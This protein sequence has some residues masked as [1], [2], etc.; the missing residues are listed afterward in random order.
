MLRRAVLRRA[1]LRRALLR[2]G[3]LRRAELVGPVGPQGRDCRGSSR[4]R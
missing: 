4:G 2:R 3:V 1:V